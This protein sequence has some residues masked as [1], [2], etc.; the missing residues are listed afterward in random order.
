MLTKVQSWTLVYADVTSDPKRSA[1][2][3]PEEVLGELGALGFSRLGVAEGK[4][5]GGDPARAVVSEVMNGSAQE[6][7]AS[8]STH[9]DSGVWEA[10]IT[11]I[12]DDGVVVATGTANDAEMWRRYGP[13]IANANL[14]GYEL[15]FAP[16]GTDLAEL[17]EL[18]RDRVRERAR[19]TGAKPIIHE[20]MS[21]YL[22][23]RHAVGVLRAER[24]IFQRRIAGWTVLAWYMFFA[25]AIAWLLAMY[26]LAF[27]PVVVSTVLA[28][29][30]FVLAG[31]I[32]DFAHHK[33]GAVL[34]RRFGRRQK[35]RL[36]QAKQSPYR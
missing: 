16:R 35:L 29:V 32:E 6:S 1:H 27:H 17:S 28:V 20:S 33:L 13:A 14:D 21:Q 30:A 7:F 24:I 10:E 34:H 25:S 26:G 23:V 11:T 9:I 12:F 4:L 31:R 15:V 19:T 18:H 5:P 2:R 36:P 8:A 3:I 22:D